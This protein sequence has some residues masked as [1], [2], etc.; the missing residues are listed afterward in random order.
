MS[1]SATPDVS[2][3]NRELNSERMA[4]SGMRR[5]LRDALKGF[6]PPPDVDEH[7]ISYAEEFGAEHAAI[8]VILPPCAHA[9]FARH[10][11]H[12]S[13]SVTLPQSRTSASPVTFVMR[14][15]A[16]RPRA[17]QSLR[18]VFA[19]VSVA[20]RAAGYGCVGEC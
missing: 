11:R 16:P 17:R 4:V 6:S 2:Y 14:Q 15:C 1:A 7:I 9:D 18:P 19:E 8:L 3:F 10:R 12:R 20:H 13:D 5:D